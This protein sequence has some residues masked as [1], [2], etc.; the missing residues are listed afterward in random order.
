[1]IQSFSCNATQTLFQTGVSHTFAHLGRMAHRKLQLLN[2][3][4]TLADL[5]APISNQF[6]EAQ[7]SDF[8]HSIAIHQTYRLYFQWHDDGPT[9]VAIANST[10]LGD[11]MLNDNM[12]PTHPGE[13]LREDYLLPLHM[14]PEALAAALHIPVAHVEELINETRSVDPEIALRL[15]RYFGGDAVSWL[16]LQQNYD[17]KQVKKTM[18]QTIVETVEPASY[19][20]TKTQHHT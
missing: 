13:I 20:N 9:R 3:A 11:P 12:P 18:L 19:R 7:S 14:S 1:M 17:L 16:N 15:T 2:S 8:K 4:V 10:A 5:I 6:L